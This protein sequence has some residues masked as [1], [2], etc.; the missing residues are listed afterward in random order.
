MKDKYY[1][2]EIE[3][4]HVGF[5]FE[6][7]YI[8]YSKNGEW[9]KVTLKEDLN[10]E[11]I[12]WFYTSYVGDAVPTEFRVKH[13]DQEDIESCGW[14]L[15]NINTGLKDTLNFHKNGK[16]IHFNLKSGE[17]MIHNEGEYEDHFSWFNGTIKNKSEFKRILKQ[18][19][20]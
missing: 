4:F 2:P 14:E 6:S 9:T 10:N 3:E 12:A 20:I 15:H 17:I 19:G 7:N 8:N 18:I 16:Y 1:T 5:E 11:D 13:L